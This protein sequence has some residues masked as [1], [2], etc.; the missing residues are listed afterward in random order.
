MSKQENRVLG[1]R[2]ARL[3]TEVESTVVNGGLSTDTICTLGV[4]HKLDGD[5]FTGDCVAS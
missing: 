5:V 4:H 1:R 3:I 2:G